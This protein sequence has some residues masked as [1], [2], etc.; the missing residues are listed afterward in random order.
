MFTNGFGGFNFFP[1]GNFEGDE[2]R[3]ISFIV[4]Q[5]IIS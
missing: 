2:G 1:G 5:Q 4:K 3:F